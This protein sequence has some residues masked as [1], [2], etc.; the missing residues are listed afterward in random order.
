MA[1][2]PVGMHRKLASAEIAGH[3]APVAHPAAVAGHFHVAHT[4]AALDML[5]AHTAPDNP[6]FAPAARTGYTDLDSL[7]AEGSAGTAPLLAFGKT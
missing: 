1:V 2:D 4:L 5:A 7:V 3:V 6:R